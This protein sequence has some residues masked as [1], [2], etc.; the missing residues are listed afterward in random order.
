MKTGRGSGRPTVADG[1][2]QAGVSPITVSRTLR[3][4]DKVSPE[5]REQVMAAV[6]ALGVA[7]GAHKNGMYGAFPEASNAARRSVCSQG[8]FS[9]GRPKWP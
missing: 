7:A 3:T 6:A 2:A 4:P 1:A 8:R 5:L 9:S